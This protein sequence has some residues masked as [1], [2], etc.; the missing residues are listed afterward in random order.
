[1]DINVDLFIQFNRSFLKNNFIYINKKIEKK[2]T[3]MFRNL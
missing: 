2:T 3:T 1:M